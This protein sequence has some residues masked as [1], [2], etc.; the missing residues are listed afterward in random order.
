MSIFQAGYVD[1]AGSEE[2]AEDD[3]GFL[4]LLNDYY[5]EDGSEEDDESGDEDEDD[6]ETD[7]APWQGGEGGGWKTGKKGRKNCPFKNMTTPLIALINR[8]QEAMRFLLA[9]DNVEA[10]AASLNRSLLVRTFIGSAVAIYNSA[11]PVDLP[12]SKMPTW[13]NAK[14]ELMLHHISA[15]Y[16]RLQNIPPGQ[17]YNRKRVC[18]VKKAFLRGQQFVDED[19]C[20]PESRRNLLAAMK[21]RCPLANKTEPMLQL[22]NSTYHD[23]QNLPPKSD[24][25][26]SSWMK[27]VELVKVFVKRAQALIES[28]EREGSLRRSDDAYE[29]R[30]AGGHE[31]RRRGG[32]GRG[33]RGRRGRGRGHGHGGHDHGHGGHDHGHGG[34]GHEGHDHG[35]H[36]R[37]HKGSGDSTDLG[38]DM[39]SLSSINNLL[40]NS[41]KMLSSVMNMFKSG[42]GKDGA[43]PSGLGA[44]LGQ[45]SSGKDLTAALGGGKYPGFSGKGPR[46]NLKGSKDM[47]KGS[48]GAW[49]N[50][51]LGMSGIKGDKGP[52]SFGGRGGPTAGMS[53]IALEGGKISSGI[54]SALSALFSGGSGGG[55]SFP[56][57]FPK[58]PKK[59]EGLMSP[60]TGGSSFLADLA[61]T[62][63][64][65]SSFKFPKTLESSVSSG[66]GV[67]KISGIDL[68][69]FKNLGIKV[70]SGVKGG[71]LG[72]S[73]S[74]GPRITGSVLSPFQ[75][76]GIKVP[77]G[78]NRGSF[79]SSSKSFPN[80]SH[81]S[82]NPFGNGFNM[83]SGMSKAF[84]WR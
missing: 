82:Q 33:G 9:P 75:N 30:G 77:S 49:M 80:F 51:N 1:T 36:D 26:P 17:E 29:E 37:M 22:I 25:D 44:V 71:S 2:S 11:S 76:L 67:P 55:S 21:A 61:K 28:H 83:P 7:G 52:V 12:T 79:G 47:G 27:R 46:R 19:W 54:P 59:M 32:H 78:V 4:A 6:G 42:P 70:P 24:E 56:A 18:A 57:A 64:G 48:L 13:C 68:A 45:P 10:S 81:K 14:T 15:T 3:N 53:D 84:F 20:D 38:V 72:S 60:G 23:M 40:A 16:N 43:F 69:P 31:D 50:T 66:S 8:T 63:S 58:F 5:P 39:P 73:G 74:G 34:H 62:P 35:P 65:A 41:E